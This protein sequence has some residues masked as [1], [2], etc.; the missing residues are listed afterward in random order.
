MTTGSGG[1]GGVGDTLNLSGNNYEGDTI[2]NL[3]GGSSR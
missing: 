3:T 2:F 1:T